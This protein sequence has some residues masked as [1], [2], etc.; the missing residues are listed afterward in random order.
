MDKQFIT[1][2]LEELQNDICKGLL[3][4]DKPRFKKTYG[5][6]PEEEG[7]EPGQLLASTL[8]KVGLIFLLFMAPSARR[9]PNLWALVLAIFLQ[10]A[11]P[12][13]CIRPIPGFLSFI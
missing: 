7:A 5:K 1:T 8:K 10:Q 3:E 9:L 4:L 6:D 11:Y 13:S 2:K 12:S